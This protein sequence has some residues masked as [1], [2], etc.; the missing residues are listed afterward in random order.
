MY[1]YI[2]N[3]MT[4]R[5]VNIN[6]KLGRTIINNYLKIVN[7]KKGGMNSDSDSDDEFYSRGRHQLRSNSFDSRMRR[8]KET[9]RERIEELRKKRE[10]E[11]KLLKER[12]REIARERA[13]EIER[14]NR[15][16]VGICYTNSPTESCGNYIV[17]RAKSGIKTLG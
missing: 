6:G 1:K 16:L 3:P 15:F 2:I 8:V 10:R 13:K 9:E 5:K 17:T 14:K 12:E 7:L 4:G 11:R